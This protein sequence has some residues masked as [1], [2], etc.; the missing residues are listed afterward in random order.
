MLS[1]VTGVT[2]HTVPLTSS[3]ASPAETF[4]TRSITDRLKTPT[5]TLVAYNIMLPL[6]SNY[7]AI[8][9]ILSSDRAFISCYLAWAA[10][11]RHSY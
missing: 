7:R 10:G 8:P 6:T 4:T 11:P 5:L 9:F 2:L 1:G 3:A